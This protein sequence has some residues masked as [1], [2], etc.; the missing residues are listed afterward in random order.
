MKKLALLWLANVCILKQTAVPDEL[1][2]SLGKLDLY[3][4]HLGPL[5]LPILFKK[6][7]E[8]KVQDSTPGLLWSQR[9]I[10][11]NYLEGK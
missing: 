7:K 1:L 2:H 3:V 9:K 11:V 4:R 5:S 8:K 6:K 10:P